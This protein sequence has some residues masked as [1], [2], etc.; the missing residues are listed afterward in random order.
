MLTGLD[1]LAQDGFGRCRNARIGVLANQCAVDSAGTHLVEHLLARGLRPALLFGPEHGLWS[2]HQDMEPVEGMEDPVFH[3]PVDSL[4]G[5]REESLAPAREKL[6]ALDVLLVDLQDIGTRY[7]TYAATV[8]K[9]LRVASGTSLRILLLDRPN[10]I[11]GIT[12]EGGLP[13]ESMRSYVGELP[14]PHRHALTL[15]ELAMACADDERLDVDLSVVALSGW[16]RTRCVDLQEPAT[17]SQGRNGTSAGLLWVPPSPNMPTVET[18]IVYPGL[19]LLEGTN[20]SEGRGTTTPFLLFGAPFVDPE[21]LRKRLSEELPGGGFVLTS[22]CFR[23]QFG[24]WS[25]RLC[26]GL[27]LH[28]SDRERFKPL[29]FGMALVKWLRLL[30]PDEFQWRTQTYEFVDDRLAIDLLLGYP[31]AR[32]RLE[33]GAA[34]EDVAADLEATAR[35]FVVRWPERLLYPPVREG[36]IG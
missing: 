11:D 16:V 36:R 29:R 18:A 27:R 20:V 10:P 6:A 26:N 28:V 33:A 21:A 34:V 25:G 19:C 12:I 15:G 13:H 17:V 22:A 24:K 8:A 9:T 35:G 30:H 1:I 5:D 32:E 2:T 14:V 31:G 23:P 7:Y 4:Y 3:L